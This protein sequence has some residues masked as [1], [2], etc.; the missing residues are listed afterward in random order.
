MNPF[1]EVIKDWKESGWFE[2]ILALGLLI[3][4]IIALIKTFKN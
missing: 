2:K 4:M 1:K 3:V